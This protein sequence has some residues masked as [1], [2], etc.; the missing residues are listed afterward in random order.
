MKTRRVQTSGARAPN[1][2]G[3][4]MVEVMMGLAVL[5]VGGTGIIAL[6]KTAAMGTMTSRHITNATSL[7]RTVIER[8]EGD[9]AQ[10]IDNTGGGNFPAATTWLG[11]ALTEA[12][13]APPSDWVAP[14]ARAAT[15]DMEPLDVGALGGLTVAYCTHVRAN[16]IGARAANPATG[17]TGA[18]S[19]RFEVRTFFARSGRSVEDECVAA[20]GVI[21]GILNGTPALVG[22]VTR[23]ASEY[24]VV[25]L[26]TVIRRTQ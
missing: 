15:I 5:A 8:A 22:G 6:Q 11:V 9:A 4:T 7:S 19:I 1:R 12:A 21:D 16:W 17:T 24:G 10:W 3:Y 20:P 14:N 13:A 2:S 23:N 18:T 25:N 26:T